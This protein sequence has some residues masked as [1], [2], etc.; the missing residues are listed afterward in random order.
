MEPA[1]RMHWISNDLHTLLVGVSDYFRERKITLEQS[2][3]AE[4]LPYDTPAE[5]RFSYSL[6]RKRLF[7]RSIIYFTVNARFKAVQ[8]PDHEFKLDGAVTCSIPEQYFND[9]ALRRRIANWQA[10]TI[11][12]DIRVD[13]VRVKGK[14]G[15]WN[16][17]AAYE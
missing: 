2:G 1:V 15:T 13:Y 12:N 8:N 5:F 4:M 9:V 6:Y 3:K 10:R 14:E 7:R 16:W 11:I 17:Q